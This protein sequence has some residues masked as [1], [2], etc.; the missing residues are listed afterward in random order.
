M[1]L[2][3]RFEES[4]EALDKFRP[5]HKLDVVEHFERRLDQ[6]VIF[7]LPQPVFG[8]RGSNHRSA[9]LLLHIFRRN[10]S[11]IARETLSDLPK[12]NRNITSIQPRR[13]WAKIE[14]RAVV[15]GQIS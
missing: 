15:I 14:R 6:L 1:K 11:L 13:T 3:V 2:R 5:T 4:V 12:S 9:L 8:T 7:E 10:R